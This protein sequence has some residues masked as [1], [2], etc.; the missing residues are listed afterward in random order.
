MAQL[1]GGDTDDGVVAPLPQHAFAKSGGGAKKVFRKSFR[2]RVRDKVRAVGQAH[3]G[4]ED[5]PGAAAGKTKAGAASKGTRLLR[6]DD[7]GDEGGG[8]GNRSAVGRRI[9]D[10]IRLKVM[11]GVM[12]IL[13]VVGLLSLQEPSLERQR[14]LESLCAARSA[15]GSEG[16]AQLIEQAVLSSMTRPTEAVIDRTFVPLDAAA[17]GRQAIAESIPGSCDPACA[18]ALG[19]RLDGLF[20]SNSTAVTGGLLSATGLSARAVGGTGV[21]STAIQLPLQSISPLSLAYLIQ[22]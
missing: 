1:D 2:T 3:M 15:V 4:E 14:V 17:V 18:A 20:G 5:D 19:S 9:S 7:S 6:A 10:L 16:D 21:N 8:D 22:L 11:L 12:V 13:V